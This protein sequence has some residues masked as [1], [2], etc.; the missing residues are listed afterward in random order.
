VGY[1]LDTNIAIE[2]GNLNDRVMAR[3]VPNA[4]ESYLS[5]LNLVE[6]ERGIAM[7]PM[8]AQARRSRLHS[9]LMTI[10]VLSFDERAAEAYGRIISQ[11]G[12]V[13]SRDYD[14]MIAAHAISTQSVLVT[15]NETDF[16]DIP[17]LKIENW[18]AG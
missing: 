13:R 4:D 2:I 9:L 1:F 18:V 5:V 17:S 3:F 6:L 7:T 10:P 12:W 15:N 16:R 8:V 14:R 11:L